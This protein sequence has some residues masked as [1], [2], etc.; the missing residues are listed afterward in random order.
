M[1]T[2]FLTFVNP[3]APPPT[4]AV[5]AIFFYV[6]LTPIAVALQFLDH[7]FGSF[8][9]TDTIGAF[10]L[11]VIVLTMVIRG[12]LFPLFRWQIRTQWKIQ[13]DQRRMGPEL[14]EIQ[15]K[16]K[17]D[18]PRLQAETMALYKRHEINPLSQLSGCFPLLIQLP[19]IYALFG[20]INKLSKGLHGHTSFLWIH[21]LDQSALKAGLLAHPTLVIVPL[22]AGVLTFAQSKMMMQQMR[23]DMTD[24][25]KQMY[26]VMRQTTYLMPV[27]IAVFALNF[28]QGIGLYW[29]TQSGI[30][31]VQIFT[32]MGWGGLKV[33]PWFP[34]E[35]WRP[36]NS[37][38]GRAPSGPP[39]PAALV[40]AGDGNLVS[41]TPR[42]PP[43]R[44]PAR[45]SKSRERGRPRR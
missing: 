12:L 29:I 15:A 7:V 22:L 16:Y 4:N 35:G 43:T 34:G 21:N 44:P 10:G 24:Q 36:K 30:M 23:P 19:F 33:P 6:L 17:K 42:R 41:D 9:P 18:K 5:F 37:P 2:E 32:M 27:L 38:M 8:G 25:E 11:A 31:V 26:N 39:A 28:N 45:R 40:A 3:A 20:S 14:R 1:G 13:A